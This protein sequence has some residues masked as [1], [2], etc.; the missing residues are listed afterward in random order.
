MFYFMEDLF[1][2][3]KFQMKTNI[4]FEKF[5]DDQWDNLD[6]Q[7][8]CRML[9]FNASMSSVARTHSTFGP[10]LIH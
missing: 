2:K 10:G 1:G 3:M 9:G 6:A 7:V 5:S 8:A 4:N